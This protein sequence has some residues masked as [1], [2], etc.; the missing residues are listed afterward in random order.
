LFG[1]GIHSAVPKPARNGGI[2]GP[3]KPPF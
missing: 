3:E 1:Q 2:P